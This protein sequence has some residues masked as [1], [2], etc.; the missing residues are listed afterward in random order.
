MFEDSAPHYDALYAWKDYEQE[1]KN[2]TEWIQR[3]HSGARSLLDVA[4]GTGEHLLHFSQNFEV[5]G[6]D[7]NPD[8]LRLAA[9]KLP[10]A[11]WVHGD[12]KS[13][14]L[15]RRF[16]VVTCLFGSIGYLTG[17]GEM[18]QA[19]D[20]MARH[21][22]DGGLLLLEGWLSPEQYRTDGQP[23]MLTVDREDLKVCRMNVCERRGD[24]SVLEMH[25][26]VGAG[27]SV[28]HYTELHEL[29][30]YTE[31]EYEEALRRSGFELVDEPALPTD[32]PTF[33]ARKKGEA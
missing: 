20:C 8:F 33:L 15:E 10:S 21:C 1:A 2:A 3:H 12:M 17:D 13:F 31:A 19:V 7:C 23:W 11:T 26:L 5:T 32:R 16:D 22:E 30:L 6:L 29:R 18:Q 4:C 9:D 14:T 27:G 25:Y 24:I 28:R